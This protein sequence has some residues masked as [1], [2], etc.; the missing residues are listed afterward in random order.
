[1]RRCQGGLICEAQAVER[2]KHF[3]SKSAFDI[4]GMG[5]RVIRQFWDDGLIKS[6]ADIFKLAEKDKKSLTPLLNKE[7]WGEQSAE[8]LFAAIEDKRTI[9]L[10]RFIYALGIRQVGQQT[11]KRLAA[12]YVS[13][14]NL[15][16]TLNHD[17][18]LGIEDIGP[19][20]ATDITAFFAED[21]NKQVLADLQ[22]ELDIQDYERIQTTESVFTG[23]TVV[24]TG[25]LSTMSRAEAKAKLESLGAKV[26][27]S[28]SA[29][30]DY[31]IAG[32]DAGSK[33]KKAKD[34]GLEI[35]DE[36]QFSSLI[37]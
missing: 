31:L 13:L 28:V 25:T 33:L 24:L 27:G 18:L 14:Q 1:V 15:I 36:K 23:K 8:K 34:L 21:H 4:D 37:K 19:A 32:E 16:D 22:A 6:P 11:A 29:K 20:V 10:E 2:L 9:S 17:E 26:S 35:L 12:H 3:V 7:G 5:D 30:T